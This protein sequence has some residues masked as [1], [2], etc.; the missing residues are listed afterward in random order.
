MTVSERDIEL[1]SAYH[2]GELGADEAAR[3]CLRIA[4]EPDLRAVLEDIR[5]MSTALRALRPETATARHGRRQGAIR[6]AAIVASLSTGLLVGALVFSEKASE[7]Q[8]PFAWH[9]AFLDQS[10]TEDGRLIPTQ[11]TQWIGPEPD[12]TLANLT[13][14][15]MARSDE[16][17]VFL[18]Y[19]GANGCRLTFGVHSQAPLL[20]ATT[21]QVLTGQWS[22]SGSHY[23]IVAMGMDT[24][25]FEAIE[26]LLRRKTSSDLND[27]GQIY[28]DAR[29]ATQNA[30]PCA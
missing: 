30:R 15:D 10:Y 13:L 29:R 24:S 6:T 27:G 1:V 22:G 2:D 5:E 8:T 12:L 11:A 7:P 21:P 9:Q 20:P 23:S 17:D 25:R 28:A 16:G 3:L 26:K 14:V 18:H 19:S 4:E